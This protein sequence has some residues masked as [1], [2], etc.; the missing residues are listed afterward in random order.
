MLDRR[1][2]TAGRRRCSPQPPLV[3]ERPQCNPDLTRQVVCSLTLDGHERSFA[4]LTPAPFVRSAKGRGIFD[5]AR[6]TG[7]PGVDE[8]FQFQLTDVDPVELKACVKG[9]WLNLWGQPDMEYINVYR[10]GTLRGKGRVASILKADHPKIAYMVAHRIPIWLEIEKIDGRRYTLVA[11]T[12]SDATLHGGREVEAESLKPALLAAPKSTKPI[13]GEISA[14]KYAKLSPGEVLKLRAT[15]IDH[16]VRAFG[17]DV[18][19]FAADGSAA[20]L[21][22]P[23]SERRRL[24]QAHFNGLLVEASILSVSAELHS[25]GDRQSTWQERHATVEIRFRRPTDRPAD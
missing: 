2:V 14:W 25:T 10:P 1:R 9:D 19:F 7:G 21:R 4:E 3:A 24:L 16:Y 8:D 20:Q 12:R 23:E 11:Q 15:P 13:A 22:A 5:P 17:L 6:T 18:Q